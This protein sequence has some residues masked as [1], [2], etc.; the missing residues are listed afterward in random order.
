M[1]KVGVMTAAD[2]TAQSKSTLPIDD[3]GREEV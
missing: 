3:R 2:G 1:E